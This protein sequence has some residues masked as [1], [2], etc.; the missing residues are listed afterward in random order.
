VLPIVP[1][2]MREARR[3]GVELLVLPTPDAIAL[4]KKKLRDTNAVLHVIC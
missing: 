3:R 1:E 2:L 4:L